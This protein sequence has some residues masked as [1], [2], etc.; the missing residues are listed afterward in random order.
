MEQLE[1]EHALK[2]KVQKSRF[3][4]VLLQLLRLSWGVRSTL[5]APARR[6]VTP[7]IPPTS[8]QKFFNDVY[9][10]ALHSGG[11][12]LKKLSK[13]IFKK[14]F[15]CFELLGSR[16]FSSKKLDFSVET[17][18]TLLREHMSTF[19]NDANKSIV[20][21]AP[22]ISRDFVNSETAWASLQQ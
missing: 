22:P 18:S 19:V 15:I 6:E 4:T 3:L 13:L 20:C 14:T 8:T 1:H 12:V 7:E 21:G 16:W 9:R 5:A 2:G 11:A 17:I 10:P